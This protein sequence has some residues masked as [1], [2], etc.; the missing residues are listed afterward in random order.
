MLR[1]AKIKLSQELQEKKSVCDTIGEELESATRKL[2]LNR[3]TMRVFIFEFFLWMYL[4]AL[5]AS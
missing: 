3:T 5:C 1:N 2:D 4:F